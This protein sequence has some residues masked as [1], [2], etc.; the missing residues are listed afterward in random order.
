MKKYLFLITIFLVSCE[1]SS[2]INK[3]NH[4]GMSEDSQS[5]DVE[6]RNVDDNKFTDSQYLKCDGGNLFSAY[7]YKDLTAE[8]FIPSIFIRIDPFKAFNNG[9]VKGNICLEEMKVSKNMTRIIEGE[10]NDSRLWFPNEYCQSFATK[11]SSEYQF[12][13]T[14]REGKR[15]EAVIRHTLD[16]DTL[17]LKAHK[18]YDHIRFRQPLAD[19]AQCSL[20][21]REIYREKRARM[22]EDQVILNDLKKAKAQDL[23]NDDKEI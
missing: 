9:D 5:S 2:S 18:E 3:T 12:H 4:V 21:S 8:E 1:E 23:L 7:D 10:N 6:P 20:S 17:V 19:S 13:L 15:N 16:R 14:Y 11:S 22:I